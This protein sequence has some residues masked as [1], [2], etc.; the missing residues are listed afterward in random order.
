MPNLSGANTSQTGVIGHGGVT[1]VHAPPLVRLQ[2][3]M[4][5]A[6]YT[7]DVHSLVY[8]LVVAITFASYWLQAA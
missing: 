7:V 6:V 5:A 3:V 4:V 1:L 8:R 2:M